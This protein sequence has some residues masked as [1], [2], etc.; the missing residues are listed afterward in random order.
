MFLAYI[1]PP[2]LSLSLSLSHTHTHTR[3]PLPST[4]PKAH[5]AA[6]GYLDPSGL[7]KGEVVDWTKTQTLPSKS[8]ADLLD[9]GARSLDWRPYVKEGKLK[10][11]HGDIKIEHEFE[12]RWGTSDASETSEESLETLFSRATSKATSGASRETLI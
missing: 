6:S 7:I 8:A 9:C 1:K 10:A 2:R 3:S 5:D 12:V 11:H 4:P